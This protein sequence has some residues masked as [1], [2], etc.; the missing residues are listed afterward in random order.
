MKI[1]KEAAAQM[2]VL[3]NRPLDATYYEAIVNGTLPEFYLHSFQVYRG[4]SDALP[5]QLVDGFNSEYPL[6]KC[7]THFLTGLMNRLKHSV[8]DEII[9]D[10]GM[11][12][13]IDE[14]CQFDWQ[15]NR[16]GSKS[17]FMTT[18]NEIEKINS[19]LDLIVSHLKQKYDLPGFTQEQIDQTITA[20]RALSRFSLPEDIR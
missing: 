2:L 4:Y 12:V 19:M 6:M 14:F 9:T 1:I 13:T 16:S 3:P 8:E 11:A 15:A 20:R 10:T 18:P 7:R 17:E 5:D